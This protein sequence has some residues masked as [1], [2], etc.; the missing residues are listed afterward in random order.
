MR[1]QLNTTLKINLLSSYIFNSSLLEK[2]FTS[3]ISS[4]RSDKG[5]KASIC[6]N[7]SSLQACIEITQSLN[8]GV[9]SLKL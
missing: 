4:I 8:L 3:K 1:G 5:Y 2:H 6:F 7:D 9:R